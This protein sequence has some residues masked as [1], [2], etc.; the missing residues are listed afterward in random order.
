MSTIGRAIAVLLQS[1]QASAN[2]SYDL[3]ARAFGSIENRL[4][5]LEGVKGRAVSRAEYDALLRK[6]SVMASEFEN[7]KTSIFTAVG[8]ISALLTRHGQVID[9][10]RKAIEND[11]ATPAEMQRLADALSE[12]H[13]PIVDAIARTEAILNPEQPAAAGAGTDSA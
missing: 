8:D 13:Q 4:E 12:T 7:L 1:A 2:P 3:L 10:L 6:V 9:A 11:A 5:K